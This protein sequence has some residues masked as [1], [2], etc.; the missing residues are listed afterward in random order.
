ML[1]E[2][3]WID[4]KKRVRKIKIIMIKTIIILDFGFW[5]LL[6][7]K[8]SIHCTHCTPA[9]PGIDYNMINHCKALNNNVIALT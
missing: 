9:E 2:I 8:V 6:E 7:L 1:I 4:V 3:Q 5:G